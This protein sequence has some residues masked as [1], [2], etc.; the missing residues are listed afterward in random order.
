MKKKISS[1]VKTAA[2]EKPLKKKVATEE[3]ATEKVGVKLGSVSIKAVADEKNEEEQRKANRSENPYFKA[4]Q[5]WSTLYILP[6]TSEGMKGLPWVK[7]MKHNNLGP[8]HDQWGPCMRASAK[9]PRENC[10]GCV[11]VSSLWTKSKEYKQKGNEEL[12]KQYNELAKK[13]VVREA[14][15]V[16]IIDV[17][18]CYDPKSGK[19][20]D[21]FP[22][23]YGENVGAMEEN[24]HTKC[25]SCP[26]LDSC[27]K[28]VQN[29]DISFAAYEALQD[30]L[31]DKKKDVCNPAKAYPLRL[32]RTGEGQMGTKYKVEWV[33]KSLALPEHVVG[34]VERRATDL[35]KAIRPSSAEQ[36]QKMMAGTGNG[37]RD[38]DET[39]STKNPKKEEK[40]SPKMKVE[41]PKVSKEDRAA[42]IAKLKGSSAS[43]H[44]K[45]KI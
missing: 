25:R 18:G 12:M 17:S 40:A 30:E 37:S 15:R 22:S 2:A 14:P 3:T 32:K 28:G 13:Q 33:K 10:D 1:K 45:G 36:M 43:K 27:K 34:F 9:E 11:Y 5:G 21:E 16:Q 38:S 20:I 42:M 24:K 8:N 19:M 35:T 29:W 44:K 7:L 26:F 23:C 6:P 4:P 31:V 39:K 41:K